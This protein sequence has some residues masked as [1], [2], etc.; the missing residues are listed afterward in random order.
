MGCILYELA[1]GNCPFKQDWDVLNYCFSRNEME[2]ILDSFDTHSIETITKH[3]VS[4]LQIDPSKGPSASILSKEF[5][6]QLR[7]AQDD[8]Q[9]RTV[10]NS[11]TSLGVNAKTE[12][13]P[14]TPQKHAVGANETENDTPS[15]PSHLIGVSLCSVAAN[16]DVE[17]VRT[18]LEA[19]AE[20]DS[21][22]NDWG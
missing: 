14:P 17:A 18:L 1:T 20:V 11:V 2:V 13:T 19:G 15:L 16:G 8:V 5:D 9:L 21:K 10:T 6:R 22:D 3:I 7:L 4:M 12:P